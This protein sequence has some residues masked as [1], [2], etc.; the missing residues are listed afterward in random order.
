MAPHL[1]L[2]PAAAY[3]R[4]RS[5]VVLLQLLGVHNLC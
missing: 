5:L 4:G 2:L 1:A 3:S